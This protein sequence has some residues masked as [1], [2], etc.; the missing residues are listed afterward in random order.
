MVGWIRRWEKFKLKDGNKVIQPQKSTFVETTFVMSS[1]VQLKPNM[2]K[3]F[4]ISTL[5]LFM[6]FLSKEL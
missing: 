3:F 1:D 6:L 4:F 5:V 2:D